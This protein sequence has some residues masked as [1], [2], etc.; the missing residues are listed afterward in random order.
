MHLYQ[1]RVKSK[2]YLFSLTT[3]HPLLIKIYGTHTPSNII[4][5]S[6]PKIKRLNLLKSVR[7]NVLLN[8]KVDHKSAKEIKLKLLASM[9]GANEETL[10]QALSNQRTI[11]IDNKLKQ[12]VAKDD[13]KLKD[14]IS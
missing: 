5:N 3:S 12:L 4:V 8:R 1:V 6:T 10:S 9:N 7:N 2:V 14:H 11:C 13:K